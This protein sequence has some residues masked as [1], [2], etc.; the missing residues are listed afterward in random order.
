MVVLVGPVRKAPANLTCEVRRQG[1]EPGKPDRKRAMVSAARRRGTQADPERF[2]DQ[3]G[4]C[5]TEGRGGTAAMKRSTLRFR[6]Q[7]LG[8]SER[9]CRPSTGPIS[10]IASGAIR[11]GEQRSPTKGPPPGCG[12]RFRER[13]EPRPPSSPPPPGAGAGSRWRP[14]RHS[15]D[16]CTRTSRPCRSSRHRDRLPLQKVCGP[17]E[18]MWHRAA[19]SIF[20]DSVRGA[21]FSSGR[22]ARA[23]Y[24]SA[25]RIHRSWLLPAGL[26]ISAGG[27]SS[28]AEPP[29]RGSRRVP[30][31]RWRRCRFAGRSGW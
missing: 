5:G 10:P 11:P 9:A 8:G 24:G 4:G 15:A 16:G 27:F 17:A 25:R 1:L 23:A 3:L 30:G 22:R 31:P 13:P 28:R 18:P 26:E 21:E 12:R 6:M 2:A 14:T 29:R 7:K 20:D 19:P